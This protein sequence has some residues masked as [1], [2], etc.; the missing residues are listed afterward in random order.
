MAPE[1]PKQKAFET[2]AVENIPPD[3]S[4]LEMLD[5]LNNS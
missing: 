5:I 2:Y 4:F 3:T 1:G